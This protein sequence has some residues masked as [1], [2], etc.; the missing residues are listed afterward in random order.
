MKLTRTKK[1]LALALAGALAD[2]FFAGAQSNGVPGDTDYGA[3]SQFIAQR[4]IFDPS[5]YPKEIRSSR[6]RTRIH[7]YAPEFS[8]AGTMTYEKG[9]FAF[10]NG[11]NDELKRVLQVNGTIAGYSVTD[12]TVTNATLL[13]TDKKEISLKI[14]DRMEQQNNG[15]QLVPLE[16]AGSD[17]G[18]GIAGSSTS[19]NGNSTEGSDNS[20][21]AAP[22][23]S[24]GNNDVLKRLMQLREQE[25]K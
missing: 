2:G 12:I 22:S 3:F 8:L 24:L 23:A 1:F 21:P 13:G 6:P 9:I 20:A 10:F 16:L 5:R 11:N 25:N 4:N 7:S 18:S 15:W 19:P 14:G 17:A